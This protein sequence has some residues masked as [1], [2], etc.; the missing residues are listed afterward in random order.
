MRA[1]AAGN[2]DLESERSTE[3]ISYLVRNTRYNFATS[4]AYDWGVR[5]AQMFGQVFSQVVNEF[6]R[7]THSQT[8]EAKPEKRA[9]TEDELQQLF[10]LLDVE[11]VRVLETRHEGRW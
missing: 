9:F 3:L 2:A 7:I 11:Y 8:N 10:D 5:S 1:R 4:P 6:N